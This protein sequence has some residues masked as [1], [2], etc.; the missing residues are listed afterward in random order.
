MNAT[1]RVQAAEIECQMLELLMAKDQSNALAQLLADSMLN[2]IK[3]GEWTEKFRAN[4]CSG[5]AE[6]VFSTH[7]RLNK[8]VT[9]AENAM[10][11]KNREVAS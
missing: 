2:Q 1:D 3:D 4:M 5:I 8:A 9:A 11:A 7:E 6:L 10:L